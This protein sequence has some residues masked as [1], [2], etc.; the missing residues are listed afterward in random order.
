MS[1]EGKVA[2][3]MDQYIKGQEDLTV[4]ENIALAFLKSNGRIVTN[5]NAE[6][7]YFSVKKARPPVEAYA[8]AGVI[9]F[10]PRALWDQAKLGWR[11]YIATDQVNFHETLENKGDVTII[12][13][14]GVI[15]ENLT[16]AVT[17]NFATDLYIDGNATG[18]TMKIQGFGTFCGAHTSYDTT[19]ADVADL[20]ALPDDTY[21]DISTLPGVEGS[22]SDDLTTHPNAHLATDW[23]EG[24]GDSEY[25]YW[26]P[27]LVNWGSTTWGNSGATWTLNC[28]DA[29]RRTAQWLR[30]TN[31]AAAGNDLICIM[32]G[33]MMS[34]F[35]GVQDSL[36]QIALP[37]QKA[38]DLGF[39][40]VLNFE[41]MGLHT[42]FSVPA[43]TAYVW[44]FKK[45]E[46]CS[47]YKSLLFRFG[48]TWVLE[49]LAYLYLVGFYGNLRFKS[50]KFFAK[51]YP[52]AIA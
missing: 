15:M 19:G 6:H 11:G 14:S 30:L 26:S 39:P 8:E 47:L 28:V 46:L 31:G 36:K 32:A 22:W 7:A 41:G 38:T 1:W 50:P 42:E 2:T 13:R 35:K 33:H 3:M 23:P 10:A 45:V 20:V 40:E 51:L 24:H 4:R 9:N 52:Y 25:D 34:D 37:H 43:N 18:N 17:D 21:F 44:N 5:C 49:K 48:P 29:L 12:K 16:E 27:K